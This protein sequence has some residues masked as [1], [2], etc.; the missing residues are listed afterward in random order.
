MA[1]CFGRD[2]LTRRLFAL[3]ISSVV[4]Y[5]KSRGTF[6]NELCDFCWRITLPRFPI[7]TWYFSRVIHITWEEIIVQQITGLEMSVAKTK[8]D[9]STPGTS[10][11]FRSCSFRKCSWFVEISKL[12]HNCLSRPEE[13]DTWLNQQ[14]SVMKVRRKNRPDILS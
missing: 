12:I 1:A 8:A 2:F 6:C 4:V 11:C 10:Y 5:Y 7:V 3:F 9:K 14:I 13:K